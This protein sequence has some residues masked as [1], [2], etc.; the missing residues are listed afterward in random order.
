M[1]CGVVWCGVVCSYRFIGCGREDHR[2][3]LVSR[4]QV[5]EY[6]L[7]VFAGSPVWVSAGRV[8]VASGWDRGGVVYL[9]YTSIVQNK[10]IK[11]KNNKRIYIYIYIYHNNNNK[12]DDDNNNNNENE[13][14]A[15]TRLNCSTMCVRELAGSSAFNT[16]ARTQNCSSTSLSW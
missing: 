15:L 12:N 9:S 6:P 7:D 4:N 16:P 14:G 13:G 11:E 8:G 3:A 1:W 2:R 10:G 5:L